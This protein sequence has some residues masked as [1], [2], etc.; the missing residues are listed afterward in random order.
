MIGAR[1][2]PTRSLPVPSPSRAAPR[3]NGYR[4]EAGIVGR[5]REER[6]ALIAAAEVELVE[7]DGRVWT[8]RKLPSAV[9]E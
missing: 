7:R 9:T 5:L 2:S 1:R 8:V 6:R 4:I 3:R